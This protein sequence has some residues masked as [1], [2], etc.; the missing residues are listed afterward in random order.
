MIKNLLRFITSNCFYTIGCAFKSDNLLW[1]SHKISGRGVSYA[2]ISLVSKGSADAL[3]IYSQNFFAPFLGASDVHTLMGV[4]IGLAEN[5]ASGIIAS[6]RDKKEKSFIPTLEEKF[7]TF[8]IKK[9]DVFN[10]Q[11]LQD[12][13]VQ[14]ILQEKQKGFFVEIGTGDGIFLSNSYALEKEFGW[15]GILAEPNKNFQKEIKKNRPDSILA[16]YAITDKSGKK[17]M[18][19]DT[20]DAPELSTLKNYAHQD[21]HDRSTFNEYEVETM[22]LNDLLSKYDAPSR[23]NYISVDTEGSEYTIL[24]DFDFNKY[25][26]DVFTVEHNYNAENLAKID[27]VLLPNGYA[28][29]FKNISRFDAWYVKKGLLEK[30]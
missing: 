16:P 29:V 23:V 24:K 30:L 22:T 17:L 10:G 7:L 21:L 18:F 8:L 26:V 20:Y 15:C 1:K 13:F 5:C 12:A 19:M 3:K 14:W 4:R 25:A 6:Y 28:R 11:L 9:A 27:S 2:L